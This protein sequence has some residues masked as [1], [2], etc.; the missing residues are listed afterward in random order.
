MLNTHNLGQYYEE[1]AC[2]LLCAKGLQLI[3]KNSQSRLGEIDLIMRDDDCLVFVEV[4]YRK[5]A[6]YGQAESS[7]T[8]TKQHKIIS[9]AYDWMQKQSIDSESCEYRFDVFAITGK[10]SKWIKNAFSY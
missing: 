2:R 10:S 3:A 9:T 1:Q 4:R 8:K 6:L 5:N 7:I